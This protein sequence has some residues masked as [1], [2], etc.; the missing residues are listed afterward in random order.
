[1]RDLLHG[2]KVRR[3]QDRARAAGIH[4][5]RPSSAKLTADVVLRA[6]AMRAEGASLRQIAA[7]LY[8]PRSTLHRALDRAEQGRRRP[9]WK[10]ALETRFLSQP[11]PSPGRGDETFTAP[12]PKDKAQNRTDYD[13]GPEGRRAGHSLG[14]CI[15]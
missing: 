15:S 2:E 6:L 14:F 1:M 8:V 10:R 13:C 3:G 12:D 4:I 5:G 11:S 7:T 9:L